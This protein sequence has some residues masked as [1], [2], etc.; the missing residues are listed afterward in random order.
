M[1]STH[2]EEVTRELARHVTRSH[3]TRASEVSTAAT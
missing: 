2:A 3:F 1:I